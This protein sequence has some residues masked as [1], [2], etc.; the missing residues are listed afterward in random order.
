MKS[1]C[2]GWD[3]DKGT[4]QNKARKKEHGCNFCK[5][6]NISDILDI[7]SEDLGLHASAGR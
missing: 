2:K 5:W 3:W 7:V 6:D 4:E 1:Q